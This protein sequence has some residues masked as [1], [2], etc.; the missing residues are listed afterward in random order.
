[1]VAPITARSPA[2]QPP[3]RYRE[4]SRAEYAAGRNV[5]FDA[6]EHTAQTVAGDVS[7]L[8]GHKIDRCGL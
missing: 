8:G 1:M 7:W 5:S 6:D 3:G 4:R 2:G